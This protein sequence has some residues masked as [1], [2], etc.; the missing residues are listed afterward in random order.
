MMYFTPE[1]EEVVPDVEAYI[2]VVLSETNQGYINSKIPIRME[3][4]CIEKL[5]LPEDPNPYKMYN[6]FGRSKG[7]IPGTTQMVD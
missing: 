1:F 2:A 3:I 6:A 5:E 4:F 7:K